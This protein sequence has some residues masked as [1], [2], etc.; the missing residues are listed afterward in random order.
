MLG[1]MKPKQYDTRN[2]E[3][4]LIHMGAKELGLDTAD[5][6]PDSPYRAMLWAVAR[7]RS[8]KALDDS[9]RRAVIEHMKKLGFK[10][11]Q[12]RSKPPRDRAPLVAKIRAQLKAADRLPAYADGMAKR[13]FG[14]NRFEW[15]TVDQ[16]WRIAS[17][18]NYDAKRRGSNGS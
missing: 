18:L 12:A 16:L 5:R 1:I 2:S 7:V 15:C 8:A 4:A 14:V 13:M 17:A 6:D 11:R 9:G 10:P 3:L